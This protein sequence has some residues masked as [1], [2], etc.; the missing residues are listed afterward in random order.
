[1]QPRLCVSLG[2]AYITYF[3]HEVSHQYQEDAY[4]TDSLNIKIKSISLSNYNSHTSLAIDAMV[5]II[6]Q[7][8]VSHINTVCGS[9]S[10]HTRWSVSFQNT[11]LCAENIV[12]LNFEFPHFGPHWADIT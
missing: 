9:V 6:L 8:A 7:V 1:M 11:R 5:I 3:K 2:Q 12:S 4:G 10:M